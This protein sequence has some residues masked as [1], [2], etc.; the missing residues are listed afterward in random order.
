M[1]NILLLLLAAIINI[2]SY[3]QERVNAQLPK[4]NYTPSSQ[5]TFAKGWRLQK[6]GQWI[7]RNN[8]ITE[9]VEPQFKVLIDA[10]STG[11]GTDNF[12]SLQFHDLT[13]EGNKYKILIKKSRG[14]YYEYPSIYEGWTNTIVYNY[15]IFDKDILMSELSKIENGKV[16]TINVKP[17]KLMIANTFGTSI[18][19]FIASDLAKNGFKNSEEPD[20]SSIM[21]FQ[22]AP[23]KEKKIVQF[24]IYDITQSSYGSYWGY[25]FLS[26][27]TNESDIQ[28][29][30]YETSYEAFNR[31][32]KITPHTT[33]T[34]N[35]VQTNKKEQRKPLPPLS[36]RPLSPVSH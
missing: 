16:N 11:L 1:R 10:G 29:I 21:F 35:S 30:Y 22:I 24:I 36:Q 20:N 7:S 27:S 23:Y 32:I 5:L 25:R 4:I 2:N 33:T 12:I 15:A 34:T 31:F 13:Y 17:L 3:S 6:D 28:N 26:G 18:F 9:E 19:K 14:G 8:R